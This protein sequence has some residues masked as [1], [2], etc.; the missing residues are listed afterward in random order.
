MWWFIGPVVAVVMVAGAI[1]E[2]WFVA[3]MVG[4][5]LVLPQ[6]LFLI[7]RGMLGQAQEGMA[8]IAGAAAI[9]FGIGMSGGIWPLMH[10]HESSGLVMIMTAL[11]LGGSS[12]FLLRMYS[13]T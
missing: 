6:L 8:Y 9:V 7:I 5:I 3:V 10:N 1:D 4:L 11:A 12:L 2:P 13:E